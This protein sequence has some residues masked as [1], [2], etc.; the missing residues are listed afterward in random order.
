MAPVSTGGPVKPPTLVAAQLTGCKS[1]KTKKVEA[2][3]GQLTQD[4]SD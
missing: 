4:T 3:Q 2:F 1:V